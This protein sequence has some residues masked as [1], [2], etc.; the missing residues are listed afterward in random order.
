MNLLVLILLSYT[1]RQLI[2]NFQKYNF[3]L[4]KEFQDFWQSGNLTDPANYQTL[5]SLIILLVFPINAYWI[6]LLAST[7][8]NRQFIFFLIVLNIAAN[9]AYPLI[10]S[11]TVE[12]H[13]LIAMYLMMFTC[14]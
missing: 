10:V 4:I 8:A 5:S 6:E 11:Y 7:N 12:S 14:G 1:F 13:P 9:F 3:R 2:Q